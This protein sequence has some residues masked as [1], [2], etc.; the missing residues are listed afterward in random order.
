MDY[1]TNPEG[2]KRLNDPAFMEAFC[3]AVAAGV[4]AFL[5]E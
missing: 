1:I 2:E 4:D 5:N 3:G